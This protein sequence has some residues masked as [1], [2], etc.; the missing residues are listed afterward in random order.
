MPTWTDLKAEE[1][2]QPFTALIS[3]YPWLDRDGDR[4]QDFN[5]YEERVEKGNLLFRMANWKISFQSKNN[6]NA[7][8]ILDDDFIKIIQFGPS[9]Q[10]KN[11]TDPMRQCTK[12]HHD[13]SC[14]SSGE[15]AS[16]KGSMRGYYLFSHNTGKFIGYLAD[17]LNNSGQ[18]LL[19]IKNIIYVEA[20]AENGDLI[21][22][23]VDTKPFVHL[24][25]VCLYHYR[26]N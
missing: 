14:V 20:I 22:E 18:N 1:Y 2:R 16:N 9:D 11:S 3:E 15:R 6:V 5:L 17:Q 24:Q 10:D 7:D 13:D 19:K 26:F 21:I 4:F 8:Q 23:E 12:I 25:P